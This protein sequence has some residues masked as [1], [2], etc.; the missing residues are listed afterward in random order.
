M[1]DRVANQAQERR[2]PHGPIKQFWFWRHKR[3]RHLPLRLLSRKRR[4]NGPLLGGLLR[5]F[6]WTVVWFVLIG[7]AAV[8]TGFWLRSQWDLP[9]PLPEAKAVVVPH[10]GTGVAAAALKSAGVIQNATAFEA[11]SYITFF[12]GDLHAAEFEF[13]PRPRS[14][15]CWRSSGTRSRW[16]TASPSWKA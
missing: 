16:S 4:D 2:D 15:T 1:I 3:L 12:D 7:G 11:L 5:T 8:A 9:G 13:R 10:G 6:L 14:P